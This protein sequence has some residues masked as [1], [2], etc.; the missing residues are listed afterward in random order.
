MVVTSQAYEFYLKYVKIVLTS[1]IILPTGEPSAVMSK[2][3]LGKLIFLL[4]FRTKTEVVPASN[5]FTA[6]KPTPLPAN[7]LW[8][9]A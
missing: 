6:C 8:K 2:N 4:N 1:I 3:T 7:A 9:P 5:E